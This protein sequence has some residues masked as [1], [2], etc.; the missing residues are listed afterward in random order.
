MLLHCNFSVKHT[1]QQYNNLS[2]FKEKDRNTEADLWLGWIQ[3]ETLAGYCTC[4]PV[5]LAGD[6]VI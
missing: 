3:E 4:Q 2:S 5:Y 1:V 6:L